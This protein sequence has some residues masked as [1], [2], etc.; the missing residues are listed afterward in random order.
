M[1][2]IHDTH[3][4]G[5]IVK[6]WLRENGGAIVLGLVLAFGSLFGLKQWQRWETNQHQ[7]A[8]SEYE[9]M[10]ALLSEG[11]LDAAVANYETLKADFSRS[12]YTSLA[13]LHMAKARLEAGQVD[14]S[15]QLLEHAMNNA[16]PA[17][18]QVVAR[19]RLARVRLDQ[20]DHEAAL[21]LLNGVPS[22]SGFEAQ[23]A[24]IR[25]DIHRL[26]GDMAEAARYYSEAL[27]A[28]EAGTGNR[29]FLE[30]KLESSGGAVEE[31]GEAS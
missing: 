11:N 24:E 7:Q 8:S 18:V 20:G 6:S 9:V 16:K 5:E 31:E 28:R 23:F 19:E 14:L 26:K 30:I 2:E 12:A 22:D 3:E 15:A 25:G 21:A 1:V 29:A 10:I 4:Q 13:S 27:D 17:A